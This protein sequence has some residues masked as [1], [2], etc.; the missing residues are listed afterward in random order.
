MIG[1]KILNTTGWNTK[2]MT[3]NSDISYINLLALPG[4]VSMST[5]RGCVVD[6]DSY[7]GFNACHYTGDDMEHVTTCRKRLC[8]MLQIPL[9]NL[10]IPRQTHSLN[11]AVIDDVPFDAN[12]LENIDALVTT[13]PNVAI[14]INTADCVPIV[15]V[16]EEA[17]V[18]A[19]AHS[20]WKGTVGKIASA[21]IVKMVECGANPLH[22]KV[23]MGPC[24]CGDCFE[25]GDEVVEQFEVHG[26]DTPQII[27]RSYGAKSHIDLPQAC[28]KSLIEAGVLDSNIT[29]PTHC[30]RC[31]STEFFSARR[32]GINSGRTLTIAMIKE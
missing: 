2:K 23:A 19:V 22:I 11:V 28:R 4:I 13:L 6:S 10:I 24:I 17:G 21:T 14:A 25:V 3:P 32:L 26:F 1:A 12:K 27:L 31:N 15:M 5:C 9:E 8:N 20:G 29:L 16:D 7:S 18:I 30:S